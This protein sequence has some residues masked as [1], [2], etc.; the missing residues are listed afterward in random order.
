MFDTSIF[1]FIDMHDLYSYIEY[2][3][4]QNKDISVYICD[5]QV[6]DISAISDS[7]KKDRLEKMMQNISVQTIHASLGFVGI[8]E[9]SPHKHGYKSGRVDKV[10][11]ANINEGKPEE[12][13]KL[14]DDKADTTILD[15]AVTEDIDYLITRDRIMKTRLPERL[16][17][18]RIY[19]K[20]HPELNIELI[21]EKED[22][23]NFLNGLL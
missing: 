21:K 23:M 18:V 12:I 1:N 17:K 15:T 14:K 16:K 13:E 5:T 4:T 20:K 3:F 19:S 9:T 8:D 7:L 6:Q 2:F 11:V 10:K 22:L